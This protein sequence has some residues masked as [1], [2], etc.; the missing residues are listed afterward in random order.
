MLL[1]LFAMAL[2]DAQQ[3][4]TQHDRN[5]WAMY[6]RMQADQESISDIWRPTAKLVSDYQKVRSCYVRFHLYRT[7]N[8]DIELTEVEKDLGNLDV[9]QAEGR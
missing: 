1:L 6:Q 5:E 4:Q 3:T 8:C 7:P 9:A 2:K